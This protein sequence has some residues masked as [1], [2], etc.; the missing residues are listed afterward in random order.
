MTG[1]SSAVHYLSSNPK[2]RLAVARFV[3]GRIK[4]FLLI[5]MRYRGATDLKLDSGK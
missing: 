4:A 1:E 5:G 2:K 3:L